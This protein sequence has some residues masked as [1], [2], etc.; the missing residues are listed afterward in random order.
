MYQIQLHII[1]LLILLHLCY[2]VEKFLYRLRQDRT[3]VK[4]LNLVKGPL[5]YTKIGWFYSLLLH[6]CIL[7]R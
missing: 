7:L 2:N 1:R 3:N 5:G 6:F 4:N